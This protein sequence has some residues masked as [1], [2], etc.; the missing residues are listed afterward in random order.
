MERQ[1]LNFSKQQT[2]LQI[3]CHIDS[4]NSGTIISCTRFTR[5]MNT[6]TRRNNFNNWTKIHIRN[7]SLIYVESRAFIEK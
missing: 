2:G 3:E 7:R 1:G 6:D 5:S 4:G